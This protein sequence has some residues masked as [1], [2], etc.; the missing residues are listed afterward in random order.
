MSKK[1]ILDK[2]TL[3]RLQASQLNAVVGGTDG[4]ESKTIDAGT[5]ELAR[6]AGNPDSCCSKSCNNNPDV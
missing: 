1:L 2:S 6:A 3:S 4:Y 5:N